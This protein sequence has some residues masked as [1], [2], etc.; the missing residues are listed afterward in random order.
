MLPADFFELIGD[1]GIACSVGVGGYDEKPP[2]I[3]VVA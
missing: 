1:A 2:G 3:L